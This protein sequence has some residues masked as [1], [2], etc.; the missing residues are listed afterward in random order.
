MSRV[1]YQ[2]GDHVPTEVLCKR[3]DELSDAVTEGKDAIDREFYM[4]IPARLE[5]DADLVISEASQ[6]IKKLEA[7]LEEMKLFRD[8]LLAL[9]SESYRDG[10]SR[11]SLGLDFD[12]EFSRTKLLIERGNYYY[13]QGKTLPELPEENDSLPS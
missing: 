1:K 12:F 11:A 7:D 4:S 5:N 13:D 6:R 2:H 9:M 8:N 10:M 3:L